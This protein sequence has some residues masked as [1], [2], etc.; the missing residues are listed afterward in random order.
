MDFRGTSGPKRART[1]SGF[2]S[3]LALWSF[4]LISHHVFAAQSANEHIVHPKICPAFGGF[5]GL[6]H[7]PLNM[8]FAGRFSWGWGLD[9]SSVRQCEFC[10]QN[11]MQHA[12]VWNSKAI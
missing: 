5:I 10:F 2:G 12:Q 11:H 4:S 8:Y 9:M 1:E 3:S 7:K 6:S